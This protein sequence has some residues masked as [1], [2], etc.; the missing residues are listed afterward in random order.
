MLNTF[1]A[2]GRGYMSIQP[3]LASVINRIYA[4]FLA[5]LPRVDQALRTSVEPLNSRLRQALDD[6]ADL[7]GDYALADARDQ[8]VL[9]SMSFSRSPFK[10]QQ[11]A[12]KTYKSFIVRQ[13]TGFNP[14]NS[15]GRPVRR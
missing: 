3:E 7:T 13:K 14:L 5:R 4:Q 12:T 2:G 9:N 11:A 10:I 15:N 6:L 1:M 8:E